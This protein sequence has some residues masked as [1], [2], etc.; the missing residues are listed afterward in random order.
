MRIAYLTQSYPPM[1]SGAAIV[2]AQLAKGMATRG[3]EVLVIAASNNENQYV[4][5]QKNI[6][7]LRLASFHNPLRVNQR[8]VLFPGGSVLKALQDFQPDIIH[9][10]EPIQMGRVGLKYAQSA[11]TPIILTTHQLP[12]FVASYLP[13][14]PVLRTLVEIAKIKNERSKVVVEAG[15]AADLSFTENEFDAVIELSVIHHIPNW[16]DC[17]D[18]LHRII[19]SGGLLIHKELSIETF[20]TPIGSL[21]KS[22]VEHPYESM[23]RTDE[24]IMYLEQKGFK[25]ATFQPHSILCFLNDFLLVARKER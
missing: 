22:L 21:A 19:K 9:A 18:E 10:H 15:N 11:G 5:R 17:I 23:L 2:A 16:R 13:E 3:H 4:V 14:I 25:M 1:V 6:T 8:F 20:E 12:W 24:F 7:V